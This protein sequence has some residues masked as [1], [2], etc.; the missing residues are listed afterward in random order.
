MAVD[1]APAHLAAPWILALGWGGQALFSGRVLIQW[2][3]SERA[4]RPVAPQIFWWLSAAAA[5]LMCAYSVLRSEMVMLP[6]YVVTLCIYVRNLWLARHPSTGRGASFFHV[7][8]LGLLLAIGPYAIGLFDDRGRAPAELPW[9]A[10]ATVGQA[11]WIGRFLV[12][13]RHAERHGK[14]EFP[15][16]FWWLTIVGSLF[17]L[18]YSLHRGDHVFIFGF[19]TSWVAPLRNLML[20]HRHAKT[21]R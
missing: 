15:A 20:H 8:T 1:A 18:M 7:V 13:W 9:L 10:I 4:R 17:L 16:A 19:V 21:A 12:Q 5:V 14:S 11:L 6:A 2:I 3:A